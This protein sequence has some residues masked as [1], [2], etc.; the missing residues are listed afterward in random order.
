MNV[1]ARD[2]FDWFNDRK[3]GPNPFLPPSNIPH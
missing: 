3:S 2:T 1:V